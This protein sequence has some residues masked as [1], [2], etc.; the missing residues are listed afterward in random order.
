[1]FSMQTILGRS[2]TCIEGY[3]HQFAFFIE[4]VSGSQW[5]IDS[6]RGIL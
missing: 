2:V 5:E 3:V 1:M 4:I 6:L